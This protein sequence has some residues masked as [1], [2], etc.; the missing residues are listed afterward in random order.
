MV[1]T[2]TFLPFILTG[3]DHHADLAS[4]SSA[5]A[6]RPAPP[7]LGELLAPGQERTCEAPWLGTHRLFVTMAVMLSLLGLHR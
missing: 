4:T 3:A 1:A 7:S 5:S 2:L 6:C